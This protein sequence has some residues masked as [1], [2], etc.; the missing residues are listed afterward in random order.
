[1]AKSKKPKKGNLKTEKT[2]EKSNMEKPEIKINFSDEELL[3]YC[4]INCKECKS[5]SNRRLTLAKLF[6][7]SLEELPLDIFRKIVPIFKDVDTVLGFLTGFTQFM[8]YQTCCT[9]SGFPCGKPD[10]EIRICVKEKGIRTCADCVDYVACTKLD[11]LKP[12]HVTLIQDLDEIKEK[13]VE[14]Y[15]EGKIKPFKLQPISI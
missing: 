9:A 5:L 11:F 10:C 2:K 7:E 3:A 4:G 15:I 12:H 1:M 14:K 8:T 6:K 13:G